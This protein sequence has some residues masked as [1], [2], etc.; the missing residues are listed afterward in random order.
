MG[1]SSAGKTVRMARLFR[2]DRR[3]LTLALDH[4]KA[5]GMIRG[6]RD[7]GEILDWALGPA[8]DA[9][10]MNPGMFRRHAH[11]WRDRSA[12]GVILAL[13][14]H[15]EGSIPGERLGRQA[16]RMLST[17]GEAVALGADAV[18]VVLVF[19]RSDLE[20]HASN[21]EAVSAVV[22]ESDAWGMPVMIEPVL[23][24]D[25]VAPAQLIDP[26]IVASMCRVA[27]ELGADIVKA[28]YVAG[29]FRELCRV[30]PVPITLRNGMVI[31]IHL[32][33]VGDRYT[34]PQGESYE[35][36][37]DAETLRRHYAP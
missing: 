6:L 16:Y 2:A 28:P 7:V 21:Y 18:K 3:S 8:T 1:P 10:L 26:E 4:P 31:P 9:V 22:R 23:W 17:I 11:R 30:L 33:K 19:G 37:P 27:V 25:G 13:D 5:R 29:V 35:T 12:S 20:V 34:G 32:F 36:L 15:F 14:I 24:G